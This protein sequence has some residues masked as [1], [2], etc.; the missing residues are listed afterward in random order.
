[1]NTRKL[2]PWNRLIPLALLGVIAGCGSLEKPYPQKDLFAISVN[3]TPAASTAKP[4]G[5]LKTGLVYVAPPYDGTMFVYK[6][7]PSK[8]TT[9]YYSGF[10]SPPDRMLG[11]SL[12]AWLDKSGLFTSVIPGQSGADFKWVLES[13]VTALYGDYSAQVPS[14]VIEMK[15]FLVDESGGDYHIRFQ[16]AYRETELIDAA[17]PDKLVD[18]WNKAYHQILVDLVSDLSQ[19]QDESAA[20]SVSSIAR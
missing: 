7:G 5:V 17:A 3:E 19:F 6:V 12:N 2:R 9:D 8:F 16:K 13:N 1:M 15:F 10:I 4:M 20:S 14:A 18:G 11:G